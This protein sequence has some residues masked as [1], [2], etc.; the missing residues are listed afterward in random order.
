MVWPGSDAQ[1]GCTPPHP[2]PSPEARA[3]CPAPRPALC[4]SIPALP[5]AGP[6][7]W[8]MVDQT[9]LDTQLAAGSLDTLLRA[10]AAGSCIH[11]GPKPAP[12]RE[13]IPW[14]PLEPLERGE[15]QHLHLLGTV[16]SWGAEGKSTP[17]ECLG[18]PWSCC[19]CCHRARPC[20]R[21]R[22][23]SSEWHRE[24]H[25]E[26][27]GAGREE[28]LIEEEMRQLPLVHSN[29]LI[30]ESRRCECCQLTCREELFLPRWKGGQRGGQGGCGRE[31]VLRSCTVCALCSQITVPWVAAQQS[32]V[33]PNGSALCP[34]RYFSAKGWAGLPQPGRDSP[35]GGQAAP[36]A[37]AGRGTVLWSP[38][39]GQ[40]LP[41]GLCPP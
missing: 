5:A 35:P 8:P 11:G 17:R 32:P 40:S 9:D 22:A 38:A 7:T 21:Q 16:G 6:S 25:S 15:P 4:S 10:G 18:V 33:F 2:V 23:I 41:T 12:C 27:H 3:L 30:V 24:W 28:Q 20:R 13:P 39:L 34:C 29:L 26:W 36:R 1:G 31:C 37:A 19:L 14:A